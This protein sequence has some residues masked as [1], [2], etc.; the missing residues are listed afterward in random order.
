MR[1]SLRNRLFPCLLL[2]LACTA[3]WG[4]TPGE[5]FEDGKRAFNLGRWSEAREAFRSF[6]IGWPSH[7]LIERAL[8]YQTL[9]E[10]RGEN[11]SQLQERRDRLASYS[12]RLS[13]L[14]DSL[15]EEDLSELEA[16]IELLQASFGMGR[17]ASP[18]AVL[19]LEPKLLKH[20][21]DRG[22]FPA[23]ADQ[24]IETL[25]WIAGYRA[26]GPTIRELPLQAALE[27]MQARALW[28]LYLSPLPRRE[29]MPILK[30]WKF[31]PVSDALRRSLQKAFAV[32]DLTVK[33][34]VALIGVSLDSLERIDRQAD[35]SYWYRYLKDRGI[36]SMEAWC[37]H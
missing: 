9:A 22:W 21:L 32:G 8:L 37:P 35:D 19:R 26:T 5:L 12:G 11:D 34:H 30:A 1:I 27:L 36:H 14:R 13:R 24:P 2:V 29:F 28:Q 6:E 25:R 20:L 3:A 15:P 4:I 16:A 31:W 33:R 18:A 17:L 10:I 23:P 7:P